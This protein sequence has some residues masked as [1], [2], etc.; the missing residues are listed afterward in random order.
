ML[1]LSYF[2]RVKSEGSD[3][4]VS[5]PGRGKV[6]K[7]SIKG[8]GNSITSKS[9]L[10]SMRISII[11]DRNRVY[12]AENTSLMN[13]TIHIG[14]DDC[15]VC[16]CSLIIG[17]DSKS[18]GSTIMMLEDKS[19]IEIGRDCSF[20][21]GA[22]IWCTDS[23]S[24]LDTNNCV[25]NR[26]RYIKI[27]DHVWCGLDVKIGKNVIIADNCMVG[28]GSIVTKSF[29]ENNVLIAGNPAKIVKTNICWDL[30]RPNVLLKKAEH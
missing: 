15:P 27:G 9:I 24:M 18:N 2:S 16:E 19:V 6:R 26:G 5:I 21:A 11:G 22:Q 8:D 17:Q 20:A 13:D 29:E 3:N 7:I 4:I 12:I 23:H 1:F 30:A 28:W 10:D 14:T 25:T